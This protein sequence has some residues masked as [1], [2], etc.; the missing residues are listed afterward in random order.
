MLEDA[1][2][3]AVRAG[4]V[5]AAVTALAGPLIVTPA[6]RQAW[7]RRIVRAFVTDAS[8]GEAR[9]P[10]DRSAYLTRE[11]GGPPLP[12]AVRR[13]VA[14]LETSPPARRELVVSSRFPIGSITAA[15]IAA[16][17]AEVGIQLVRAGTLPPARAVD[18]GQVLAGDRMVSR[19]VTLD[20]VRTSVGESV[21]ASRSV[22]PIDIVSPPSMQPT[23]DAALAAVLDQR[24]WMPR[25]DRR[26]RV[27]IA[28]DAGAAPP[29]AE[30]IRTPWIAEAVADL[31]GDSDLQS[32]AA[33]AA[34]GFA[35]GPFSSA[36]WLTVALSAEGRPLAAAAESNGRLV[37]VSAA[38]PSELATPLLL[39]SLANLVGAAPDLRAAEVL[40]IA[41]PQLRAWSRPSTPPGAPHANAL[42]RDDADNDR[43]WLWAAALV[44]LAIETWMRRA[45]T[46]AEK[47]H[48]EAARVA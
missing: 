28:P 16:V 34:G 46:A 3:L 39:R 17:P 4:I 24:V 35:G 1:P 33:R 20:G 42:R 48:E 26:A 40:P 25:Q 22:W 18:G 47:Q 43:R 8:A 7:D 37:V 32:A 41:D 6:R 9:P 12:D 45:R 44:L 15:D 10:V 31:I 23:V 5:A 14:W 2:L 21:V 36:P 30:S 38:P 11:F 29:D 13:A 27:V 19:Q